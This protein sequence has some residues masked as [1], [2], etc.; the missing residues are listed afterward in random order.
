MSFS[1]EDFFIHSPLAPS[2]FWVSCLFMFLLWSNFW[3]FSLNHAYYG[4]IWSSNFTSHK[5][6]EE[7]FRFSSWAEHHKSQYQIS[8][9]VKWFQ[10]KTAISN[11]KR[12]RCK[13]LRVYWNPEVT[14]SIPFWWSARFLQ[15]FKQFVYEKYFNL[16]YRKW[17]T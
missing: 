7:A 10:I 5:A 15:F 16:C 3:D 2:F 14:G 11:Q 17:E 1:N 8:N 13:V 6:S 4:E 9:Q 12:P